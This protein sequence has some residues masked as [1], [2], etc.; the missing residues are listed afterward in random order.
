V[1]SNLVVSNINSDDHDDV[2][3]CDRVVMLCVLYN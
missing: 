3:I 1:C 2:L